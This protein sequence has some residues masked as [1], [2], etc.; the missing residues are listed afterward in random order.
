METNLSILKQTLQLRIGILKD[1]LV[2]SVL[3]VWLVIFGLCLLVP[4]P[5]KCRGIRGSAFLRCSRLS[6]RLS[7]ARDVVAVLLGVTGVDLLGIHQR[8]RRYRSLGA[9]LRE[10]CPSTCPQVA[11]RSSRGE[12]AF[13]DVLE[14]IGACSSIASAGP[15]K[16]VGGVA[17]VAV[18]LGAFGGVAPY[19]G[20]RRW[21]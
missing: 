14:R 3:W 9:F 19:P 10:V 4:G 18:C 21:R 2:V 11:V 8:Y 13:E 12:R 20:K 6:R 17:G 16:S 5:G 15:L 1:M 7:S